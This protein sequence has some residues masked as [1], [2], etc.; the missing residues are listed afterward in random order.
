MLNLRNASNE[1][2]SRALGR[3]PRR[4]PP[5]G[6]TTV[7]RVSASRELRRRNFRGAFVYWYDRLQWQAS[8]AMRSLALP[9]VGGVFSAVILLGMWVVPTYPVRADNNFDV[10]TTLTANSFMGTATEAAVKAT[11]PVVG[12][13][14]DVVVD[15]TIDDRG[16]IVEYRVVS[17]AIFAKDPGFRRRL[18]NLLLF[19]EFVPATAFGRP[20]VSRMRLTL[21]SSSVEV[22]G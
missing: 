19:T 22:K 17:G 11:G 4:L 2:L 1:V 14:A 13:G 15:I 18:E 3:L 7:L 5:P 8:N 10:P 21:T 9:V 20:G 12:A 6:L 16:R